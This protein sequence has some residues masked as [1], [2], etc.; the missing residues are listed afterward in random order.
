MEIRFFISEE[1]I[2]ISRGWQANISLTID[3]FKDLSKKIKDE[4]K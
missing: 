1:V 4:I 2:Y 3:E